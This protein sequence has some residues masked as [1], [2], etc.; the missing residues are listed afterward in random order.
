VLRLKLRREHPGRI[1]ALHRR[2]ARWYERNGLLTEAV[3][4]AAQAG[5]WQLA[6]GMVIG[7][8]AIGEIIEPR[9]SRSL[10]D[11]FR[12]MPD[13][14]AWAEPQP[15]LVCAAV[16]LSDGRPESAAAA[17][18]AADGIL[19]LLPADQEA[20]GRLAAATIRFAAARRTGD[21]TAVPAAAARAEVLAGGVP[22]EIV[23]RALGI[24][25]D[26]LVGALACLVA[27]RAG[28]AEGRAAVA[29]QMAARARHGWSVPP[30]LEQRLALVEAQACAAA[31][32]IPAAASARC[33]AVCRGC[34]APP[35][36]P[37]SCTSRS[38]PSRRTSRAF[39][40]SWRPRIAARRSAAR[41]NSS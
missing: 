13:D 40:G 10:A 29:G 7:G 25:P 23:A 22:A 14:E 18:A 2:A 4:H 38:T 39:T 20:P 8:L 37:A 3:R 26:K 27:A 15:H 12:G 28:L 41:G 16:A 17:L 11:G 31:G 35:R 1:P 21:L 5:D 9:G 34:S 36:S 32:D 6:A 19:D 24:C 33:S 30:W